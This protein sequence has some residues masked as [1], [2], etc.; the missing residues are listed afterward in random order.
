MK[1]MGK[2][3]FVP[4]ALVVIGFGFFFNTDRL[5]TT[6]SARTSTAT[7][8][9]PTWPTTSAP[10]Q[11][12][13]NWK[14][15][16]LSRYGGISFYPPY[17]ANSTSPTPTYQTRPY[18]TRPYPTRRYPTRPYP[19]RRYPTRRYST[20]PYPTRP[21]PT[22]PD[23]TWP[24]PTWPYPTWPYP[25]WPYP[26]EPH[27]THEYPTHPY[28]THDYPTRPYP[29][30]PYPTHDYPTRRYTTRPY[31]TRPYPTRP[32]TT[33]PYPT[34]SYT[35]RPY[36]TRRYTTRP[37]PTRPY[38]ATT[39]PSWTTAP[40][41]TGVSVCLRYL[42][43]FETSSRIFTLS[44]ASRNPMFLGVRG[45]D[46]YSLYMPSSGYYYWYF[47]PNI[48]FQSLIEPEIWTRVCLTV[49]TNS[50]VQVFSGSNM[51]IRKILPFQNVWSG[52]PMIE[53][54]GIDGQVTDVQIWDYALSHKEIFNYMTR[55]VYRPYQGSV[56]TWSDVSYTVSGKTLFED[57]YELLGG[58]VSSRKRGHQPKAERKTWKV[59]NKSGRKEER[60]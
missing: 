29:T 44:P 43:D 9:P 36:P 16:T 34:R 46:T 26:T 52:E 11:S 10:P 3:L 15:V 60:L 42:I 32:Y 13:L 18:P 17:F 33:R 8:R 49:D 37:Y 59:F 31:P 58:K 55:G 4:V 21:Y 30:H 19:T 25:T 6:I 23:P 1:M 7:Q 24:Y 50:V 51:S 57:S 20:W 53:F 27:P 56:L 35:T 22:W 2:L 45:S 38:P 14:M 39:Y 28:P 12:N 48:K 41:T 47:K 5:I 40:P 54:S